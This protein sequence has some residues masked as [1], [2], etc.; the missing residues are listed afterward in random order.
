MTDIIDSIASQVK[1]NCNISD[2]KYWGFYSPCGLLLRLR[3]LYRIEHGLNPWDSIRHDSIGRWIEEREELWSELEDLDYSEIE[4]QG[5]R[6]SPFDVR[7]IGSAL[8]KHDLVYSA[9]YGDFLKPVFMLAELSGTCDMGRYGIY[10]AGREL[11]RDLSAS[12]AMIRGDTIIARHQTMR[13][14]LW[15][16]FEEMKTRRCS[17][18]LFHAFAEYGISKDAE[19]ELSPEGLEESF[20]RLVQEELSAYIHHEIGEASQRRIL[21]RW[22]RQLITTIPYSRA[23]LFLRGMKDVLSDTCRNGMLSYIIANKKTGSLSFYVALLGGFRRDIFPDIVT[24]YEEFI[25]TR[26]WDLIEKARIQGHKKAGDY[27]R[28]LKDMFDKGR[29]SQEAIEQELMPGK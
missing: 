20:E 4:I 12:P 9:G 13:L 7:G 15:G 19:K 3:D 14:F 29:A 17:G 8:I 11:A 24:A 6:Y 26:N 23:E 1:R 25:T 18:A 5:K 27:V 2:A 22:W 10:I 16:K 21:G 28:E